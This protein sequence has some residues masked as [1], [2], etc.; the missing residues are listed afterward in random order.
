MHFAEQQ[1]DPVV[2]PRSAKCFYSKVVMYC[3]LTVFLKPF[4]FSHDGWHADA[5]ARE[6]C[7]LRSWNTLSLSKRRQGY[8]GQQKNDCHPMMTSVRHLI[9]REITRE[10]KSSA[11][12]RGIKRKHKLHVWGVCG[13][14]NEEVVGLEERGH[15]K[16]QCFCFVDFVVD[17]LCTAS[18]LFG[19]RDKYYLRRQFAAW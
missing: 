1:L 11:G 9:L 14:D 19:A 17:F 8:L 10:N 7:L 16:Q 18:L 13:F 15:E 12:Q 5:P 6:S 3:V 2:V 4:L